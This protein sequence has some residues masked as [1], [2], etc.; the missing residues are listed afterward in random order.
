MQL[1]QTTVAPSV[2]NVPTTDLDV[3]VLSD[4]DLACATGGVSIGP[5]NGWTDGFLGG[6]GSGW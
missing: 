2:Q 3:V 5:G 1:T 6:P 4:E